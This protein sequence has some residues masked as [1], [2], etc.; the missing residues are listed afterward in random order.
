MDSAAFFPPEVIMVTATPEMWESPAL[1]AEEQLIA[2][3]IRKRQREFRAGRHCAHAALQKFGLARQAIL[4]D[5]HRAP[6]WPEGYLGSISHCQ[7]LC[8]AACAKQHP[9]ISLGLDV[10]PLKPL[11][12]GVEQYIQTA[13]ET[14]YLESFSPRLP[15]RLVFS[16]KESLYKCFYPLLKTFF[17]FHTVEVVID[18]QNQQ[19]D[20]NPGRDSKIQFPENLVFYGRYM[21]TATHLVTA[22]YLM[23]AEP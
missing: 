21:V 20:F 15:Q 18:H 4:R 7:D 14:A 19:F 9:I 10:E 12:P 1:E 16:A 2:Q 6:L 5:A 8:I 23:Q 3:A 17:G 22:C 13:A 11:K